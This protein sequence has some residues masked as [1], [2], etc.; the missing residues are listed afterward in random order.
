[1]DSAGSDGVLVS[2]DASDSDDIRWAIETASAMWN[3]ADYP[4]AL[5]WLRRAAEMAAEE[6]ADLRAV[7]LAKV[8]AE[9]RTRINIPATGFPPAIAA[10]APEEVA[11]APS[12]EEVFEQAAQRLL[13]SDPP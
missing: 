1:M 12:S 3:K 10:S 9:L 2:S 4:E 8:A 7:E 5:R 6:G 13:N 11:S